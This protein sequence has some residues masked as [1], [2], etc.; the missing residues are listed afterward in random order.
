[1]KPLGPDLYAGGGGASTPAR[2]YEDALVL[3]GSH[4]CTVAQTPL[5]S[6]LGTAVP[7]Y[8]SLASSQTQ[9]ACRLGKYPLVQPL[10]VI[11]TPEDRVCGSATQPSDNPDG[12]GGFI[13]H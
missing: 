4:P 11:E 8:K 5:R 9:E 12:F 10:R 3:A 2:F 7:S 13:S 6:L 1:M